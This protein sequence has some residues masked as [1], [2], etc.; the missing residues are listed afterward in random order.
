MA[1]ITS[2]GVDT[3]FAAMVTSGPQNGSGYT[4]RGITAS[5]LGSDRFYKQSGSPNDGPVMNK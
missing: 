1:Y 3:H 2:G 5:H 4:C